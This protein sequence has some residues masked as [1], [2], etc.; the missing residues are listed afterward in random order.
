MGIVTETFVNLNYAQKPA[1]DDI[2]DLILDLEEA[3]LISLRYCGFASNVDQYFSEIQVFNGEKLMPSDTFEIEYWGIDKDAWLEKVK[4][5]YHKKNIV[6]LIGQFNRVYRKEYENEANM[7]A[8]ILLFILDEKLSPDIMDLY[9]SARDAEENSEE[10]EFGETTTFLKI[11]S[12]VAPDAESLKRTT[13]GR[14]F[15]EKYKAV[16]KSGYI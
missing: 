9:G 13:F 11:S 14:Y 1:L 10:I 16:I 5:N 6:L 8:P 4:Q 12:K 3:D 15:R 2:L 7:Y